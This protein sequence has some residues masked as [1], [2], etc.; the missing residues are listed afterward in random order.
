MVQIITNIP[1]ALFF[2]QLSSVVQKFLVRLT[3]TMPETE[4]MPIRSRLMN[5]VYSFFKKFEVILRVP[6][7][8]VIDEILMSYGAPPTSTQS[9]LEE[10]EKSIVDYH[11][12]LLSSLKLVC[13]TFGR[14][15]PVS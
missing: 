8:F 4:E 11:S 3:C 1:A 9:V 10:S 7:L 6:P 13:G 2:I 5:H 14:Y 12:I 15:P